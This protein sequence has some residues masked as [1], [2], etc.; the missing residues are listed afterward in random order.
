MTDIDWIVAICD[1]YVV[2]PILLLPQL[3]DNERDYMVA[4]GALGQN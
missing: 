1:K 4:L 3:P 2:P